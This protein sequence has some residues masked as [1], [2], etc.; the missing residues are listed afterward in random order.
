MRGAPVL[1][2]L[3]L[4]TAGTARADPA[5]LLALTHLGARHERLPPQ[6]AG[7]CAV[8]DPVRLTSLSAEIDL[9]GAPVLQ[10]DSARALALW[11]AQTLKP[12]AA[13]MPGAPRLTRIDTGPGHVCRDR[14]GTGED[15]PKPS[16]HATGSAIDI[17]G[18]GFAGRDDLPVIPREGDMDM[19]FQRAARAGA[20]LY[21]TTV[22]GPGSN[23]AH[24]THLHLD[25]ARRRGDWR[26]C[27]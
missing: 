8:P 9:P 7:A 18:F 26:L 20:C 10:C 5:C 14:V 15:D 11:A 6:G 24:E 21:F 2:L 25:L 1:A 19:A 12:A 4:A 17:A 27:E 16:E 22:L 13:M 23:A 3:M